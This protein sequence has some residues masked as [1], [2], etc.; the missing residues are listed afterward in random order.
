MKKN[1]NRICCLV[2]FAACLVVPVFAVSGAALAWIEIRTLEDLQ[3]IQ[4]DLSANYVLMNDL[5]ASKASLNFEPIGSETYPFTGNLEGQGYK[6]IGL[7][8]HWPDRRLV[9]L[10]KVLNGRVMRLGLENIT[11]TGTS[12]IGGVAAIN[13]GVIQ[14]TYL[15]GSIMGNGH[16]IGG[17][18]GLN[19][20]SVMHSYTEGHVAGERY[21]GG[22]VGMNSEKRLPVSISNTYSNA[23][24]EGE[25]SVGG[26]VGCNL[27]EI[28]ISY[29]AG[30]VNG[31]KRIGG[32]VGWNLSDIEKTFA[33][34]DVTGTGYSTGG[35]V[36]QNE[37][38]IGE[39]F[40]TSYVSGY[41]QVGGVIGDN[42]DGLISD[43]FY[44]GPLVTGDDK[45]GGLV[46]DNYGPDERS[47]IYYSLSTGPVSGPRKNDKGGLVGYNDWPQMGLPTAGVKRVVKSYWDKE[48][49]NCA[50]SKAGEGKTTAQLKK[51]STYTDWDFENVW[52]IMEDKGVYP[53]LRWRFT[54][55]PFPEKP[56]EKL[57]DLSHD[58]LPVSEGW[59]RDWTLPYLDNPPLIPIRPLPPENLQAEPFNEKVVLTW[60]PSTSPYITE[61][62]IYVRSQDTWVTGLGE[63]KPY[64][65]LAA[66]PAES[67][68]YEH[69]GLI[70]DRLYFYT[71]RSVNNM[72]YASAGSSN[73]ASAAP[74]TNV[75]QIGEPVPDLELPSPVP[76]M[77]NLPIIK[78]HPPGNLQA[79][80]FDQK[81]SIEW[82]PSPSP[83]IA[84][85]LL[86]VKTEHSEIAGVDEE[87]S[88]LLLAEVPAHQTGYE[89]EGLTNDLR[90]F[91]TTRS[92]NDMG[93][94]STD[95]SSTV[96]AVPG[97][98]E[99]PVDDSSE[100][101]DK[102]ANGEPE[103]PEDDG[104]SS[105]G[106]SSLG[107]FIRAVK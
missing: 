20:G 65:F 2:L 16:R 70:N 85:Y 37:G 15:T 25:K 62:R 100:D 57:P 105:D 66:V 50:T 104:R 82:E 72:G 74:G 31:D 61:Y 67:T 34:G 48:A 106:D 78:P 40:S 87:D 10:F 12:D 56:F 52:D 49:S 76:E 11:V 39:S 95:P 8:I 93:Y 101:G 32:L 107:C 92:V 84:G 27:G 26:L 44:R 88:F 94:M 58:P 22:L 14:D 59:Y 64:L 86:Y 18:V 99:R 4:N 46:G 35:L 71:M 9:G 23:N 51:K 81:V 43:S 55:N 45:V 54:I 63:K 90:Y 42:W 24:V 41:R 38:K 1:K 28:K 69:E 29:A 91:Y 83:N 21:I 77:P 36:G 102:P 53:F 75:S 19:R 60:E 3:N 103:S 30:E 47:F 96:S 13:N 5:D 68:E 79:E 33:V 73:I 89:H 17:L 6:I 98:G 80:A 97:S 7:R